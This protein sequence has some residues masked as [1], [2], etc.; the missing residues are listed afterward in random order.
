VYRKWTYHFAESSISSTIT[1]SWNHFLQ[2]HIFIL[3][4]DIHTTFSSI[5]TC[6]QTRLPHHT[7]EHLLATC[8]LPSVPQWIIQ[9][10]ISQC[11][12]HVPWPN[13]CLNCTIYAIHSIQWG[14]L[15]IMLEQNQ[16]WILT[17]IMQLYVPC[18]G[19]IWIQGIC[20]CR[21]FFCC[22]YWSCNYTSNLH[23]KIY[24]YAP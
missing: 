23:C 20:C 19:C 15:V 7:S 5:F 16:N 24:Q 14:H 6:G 2:V 8:S 18:N 17:I 11:R 22:C 3:F 4:Q 13:S 9:R 12:W 10:S 21:R 1:Y